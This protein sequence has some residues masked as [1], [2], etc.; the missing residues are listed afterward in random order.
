MPPPEPH[1]R[2][3][4]C[5]YILDGL[6]E[7]RCPEC[8]RTFDP[9][10]PTTYVVKPQCGLP[11]LLAALGAVCGLLAAGGLAAFV[12]RNLFS[13]RS[14]AT[15]RISVG[16]VLLLLLG[17]VFLGSWTVSRCLKA[18][19]RPPAGTCHRSCYRMALALGL[20]FRVLLCLPPELTLV[21][22]VLLGIALFRLFSR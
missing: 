15:I 19:G 4:T 17:S 22:V 13:F 18:L 7:P 3:L 5:G 10:D 21:L 20:P 2:C 6:P 1:K 9:D 14:A 12:W 8:G 16:A 11:C